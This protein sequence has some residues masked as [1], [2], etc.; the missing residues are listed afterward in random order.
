ML[1]VVVGFIV[2][3]IG[4]MLLAAALNVLLNWLADWFCKHF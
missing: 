3:V 4:L 2:A 1:D